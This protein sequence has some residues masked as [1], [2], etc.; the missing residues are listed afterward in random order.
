[1]DTSNFT[2]LHLYRAFI[3]GLTDEQ[4][5]SVGEDYSSCW[6]YALFVHTLVDLPI[7]DD[8]CECIYNNHVENI[9]DIPNVLEYDG[10][11]SFYHANKTEFHHFILIVNGNDLQLLSTYGGQKDIIDIKFDKTLWL[12]KFLDLF[13]SGSITNELQLNNYK[14]LFGIT[15]EIKEIDLTQ[16][17]FMYSLIKFGNHVKKN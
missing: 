2:D 16:C 5:D 11:Y 6:L 1:M 12:I 15:I 8:G 13:C 7:S 17:A 14:W 9:H 4:L 10:I 3:K